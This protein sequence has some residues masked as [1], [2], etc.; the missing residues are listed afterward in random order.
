MRW[1]GNLTT[2]GQTWFFQAKKNVSTKIFE[3]KFGI[4]F[5]SLH[6]HIV[7]KVNVQIV[8]FYRTKLNELAAAVRSVSELGAHMAQRC[9][10]CSTTA[11]KFPYRKLTLFKKYIILFVYSGLCKLFYGVL[12]HIYFGINMGP[13]QLLGQLYLFSKLL[14]YY[15]STTN[16]QNEYYPIFALFQQ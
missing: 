14:E 16:S 9:H 12:Y 7:I 5:L 2:P 8:K 6:T 10:K 13:Q 3:H 4:N 1:K 15:T 11:F